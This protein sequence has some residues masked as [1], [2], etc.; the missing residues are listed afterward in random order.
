MM[1]IQL[2]FA[3]IKIIVPIVFIVM[4][5]MFGYR[6]GEQAVMHLWNV[7]KLANQLLISDQLAKIKQL[8]DDAEAANRAIEVKN[9]E[10]NQQIDSIRRD[11]AD[12]LDRRLRRDTDKTDC[13]A[14][15][16]T[17]ETTNGRDVSG[18]AGTILF[19]EAVA[20][21]LEQRHE[22]ADRLTESL[23][24]CRAYIFSIKDYQK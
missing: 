9:Y 17:A 14:L 2:I 23:R 1:S 3:A 13:R 11:A 22:Q 4:I 5:F 20:H 12:D 8:G 10:H 19:S 16:K 21:R 15:P 7:E 6:R 18:A 24:A